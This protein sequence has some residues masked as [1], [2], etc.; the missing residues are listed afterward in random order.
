MKRMKENDYMSGKWLAAAAGVLALGVSACGSSSDGSGPEATA[1][2]STSGSSSVTAT[3]NGSG[4]TFAAPISQQLG[5]ELRGQGLTINSHP[6]GPGR[7]LP[8]PTKKSPVSAG[9][10]PPMKDEEEA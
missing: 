4:S 1:A 7:G 2:A 3:L 10:D 6:V 8:A 5:R 9:S